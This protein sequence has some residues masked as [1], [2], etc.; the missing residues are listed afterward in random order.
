MSAGHVG[1]VAGG[2]RTSWVL[3]Q[4]ISYGTDRD[5]STVSVC[6]GD[7]EPTSMTRFPSRE[8][9]QQATARNQAEV[10]W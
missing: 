2:L 6:V 1:K 7:P 4:A 10:L 8:D 5:R 3:H 9:R